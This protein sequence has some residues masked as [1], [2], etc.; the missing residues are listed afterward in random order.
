MTSQ[1]LIDYPFSMDNPPQE[2]NSTF[3]SSCDFCPDTKETKFTTK[4]LTQKV[5]MSTRLM[6]W[7]VSSSMQT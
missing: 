7:I 4:G 2:T 1:K 6:V 3:S 5:L